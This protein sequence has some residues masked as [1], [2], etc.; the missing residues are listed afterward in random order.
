MARGETRRWKNS[1]PVSIMQNK[2]IYGEKEGVSDVNDSIKHDSHSRNVMKIPS[3]LFR[4]SFFLCIDKYTDL[5][6]KKSIYLRNNR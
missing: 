5:N 4:L 1:R 6:E 3:Q 2:T